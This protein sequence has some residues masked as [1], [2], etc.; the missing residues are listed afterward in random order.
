[1]S[2]K[3][4]NGV[5]AVP[6]AVGPYSQAAQTGS[7]IFLSGQIPLDPET[8]TL[9]GADD[10]QAQ[11][12]QV[13]KNLQS[14]LQGLGLSFSNVVKTGIF[15]TDMADF[16]SVNEIYAEAMGDA[17]PARATVAVAA[18]PLGA[19]VEIEMIAEAKG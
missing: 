7:L 16:Q 3:Y 12:K 18:L 9:V 1:M 8:K 17:R 19:N 2:V 13:M 11:T 14:L 6:E 15:L 5:E 10:I 4:I